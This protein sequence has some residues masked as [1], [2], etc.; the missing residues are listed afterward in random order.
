[1]F[2]LPSA[3]GTN[4]PNTSFIGNIQPQSYS[5]ISKDIAKYVSTI[6][7]VGSSLIWVNPSS[8]KQDLQQNIE[9]ALRQ[10]GFSIAPSAAA[11]PA[12]A[13]EMRYWIETL[14]DD[15]QSIILRMFI[16]NKSISRVFTR[17]K[18]GDFFASSPYTVME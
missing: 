7:P 11:R 5:V 1:M 9:N 15:S 4:N 6:L 17:S 3:C 18:N 13:F 16:N 8:R 10:K 14:D 12:N 2:L